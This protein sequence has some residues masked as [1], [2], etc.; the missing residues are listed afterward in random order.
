MN[1]IPLA[2]RNIWE[3][4]ICVRRNDFNAICDVIYILKNQIGFVDG[5]PISDRC[6]GTFSTY[7]LRR[8]QKFSNKIDQLICDV[9]KYPSRCNHCTKDLKGCRCYAVTNF[10]NTFTKMGFPRSGELYFKED[11]S[12]GILTPSAVAN[13][14]K[15][16]PIRDLL[17]KLKTTIGWGICSRQS[18]RFTARFSQFVS[19]CTQRYGSAHKE[20]KNIYAL[21]WTDTC[22]VYIGETTVGYSKRFRKHCNSVISGKEQGNVYDFW[23]KIGLGKVF[24]VPIC[25]V[26][27]AGHTRRARQCIESELIR[28]WGSA[29]NVRSNLSANQYT[30]DGT[31]LVVQKNEKKRPLMKNRGSPKKDFTLKT[32][33]GAPYC[34]FFT[35]DHIKNP[36]EW[37]SVQSH[38]ARMSLKP[39][40]SNDRIMAVKDYY[41][42]QK[43][44]PKFLS[45]I[46]KRAIATLSKFKLTIF[47]KNFVDTIRLHRPLQFMKLSFKSV[48]FRDPVYRAFFEKEVKLFL[49][50]RADITNSKP[51]ILQLNLKPQAPRN[52][53]QYYD[54]S[55]KWCRRMDDSLN[56]KCNEFDPEF[57]IQGHVLT[58]WNAL[59]KKYNLYLPRFWNVKSRLPI[60]WRAEIDS[61]SRQLVTKL[62]VFG[63]RLR[64]SSQSLRERVL[65]VLNC[66]GHTNE[67]DVHMWSKLKE[68]RD[69]LSDYVI[70][71]ID[72]DKGD[73]AIL[74]PAMYKK[75]YVDY[76][77]AS[78]L[79]RTTSSQRSDIL[80]GFFKL[81]TTLVHKPWTGLKKYKTHSWGLLRLLPKR[82]SWNTQPLR[83][84]CMKYRPLV[85]YFSN[86]FAPL[87]SLA[88]RVLN[89][90]LLQLYGDNGHFCLD[91]ATAVRRIRRFRSLHTGGD[92]YIFL[93]NADIDNFYPKAPRDVTIEAVGKLI[94]DFRAKFRRQYITIP[95]KYLNYR[96]Q[97][98]TI[99]SEEYQF[100]TPNKVWG[101]KP[102]ASSH[103]F[104]K[105]HVSVW[106]GSDSVPAID[107][108]LMRIILHDLR[109]SYCLA[110][111]TV[112]YQGCGYPQGSPL[113]TG[114][115]NVFANFCELRHLNAHQLQIRS[116][117]GLLRNRWIDDCVTLVAVKKEDIHR[118]NFEEIFAYFDRKC[119]IYSEDCPLSRVRDFTWEGSTLWQVGNDIW[120]FPANDNYLSLSL[121]STI[122]KLSV[123]SG[124]SSNLRSQ[125]KS[126][127]FGFLIRILDN[128]V[129]PL[130]LVLMQL[131]LTI[132]HFKVLD[133][134]DGIII[135]TISMFELRYPGYINTFQYKY[136]GNLYLLWASIFYL[137]LNLI[138]TNNLLTSSICQLY[139]DN[140][141]FLERRDMF[142]VLLCLSSIRKRL[143]NCL[144]IMFPNPAYS[145]PPPAPKRPP[146]MCQNHLAG[147]C[148]WGPKCFN[149]HIGQETV[150]SQIQAGKIP[151]GYNNQAS[152]TQKGYGS[153]TNYN[154]SQNYAPPQP[155]NVSGPVFSQSAPTSA[156]ERVKAGAQQ[157]PQ[158]PIFNPATDKHLAR[159]SQN[160]QTYALLSVES[161]LVGL[162]ESVTELLSAESTM[163]GSSVTTTQIEQALG[164]FK[165]HLV[166]QG[167][168]PKEDEKQNVDSDF[169][170]SFRLEIDELRRSHNKTT[171]QLRDIKDLLL[172]S[173]SDASENKR[174][175]PC[176]GASKKA[177]S[178]V[179]A[180]PSG[181]NFVEDEDSDEENTDFVMFDL[182]EANRRI[183]ERIDYKRA[184]ISKPTKE[185][186]FEWSLT[187]PVPPAV[188]DFCGP[189][190]FTA[191]LEDCE[192][193]PKWEELVLAL[194]NFENVDKMGNLLM[195]FA[196]VVAAFP[197]NVDLLQAILKTF[198]FKTAIKGKKEMVQTMI[199]ILVILWENL[200]YGKE[201]IW[202][203]KDGHSIPHQDWNDV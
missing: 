3:I 113:G 132:Y 56:C 135:S 38:V 90:M 15:L 80:G 184:N 110:G 138:S 122:S 60:H 155:Y 117:Q 118:Q 71:E 152:N 91:M 83:W 93:H 16:S 65:Q 115:A 37:H 191:P 111:A 189:W 163:C 34:P 101:L 1:F 140:K 66:A 72:K 190:S 4:D 176:P 94:T 24:V 13:R 170:D 97:R 29:L 103:Y 179:K 183:A 158:T 116:V 136:L 40:V 186:R 26:K 23:R 195:I 178:K 187:D 6:I 153:Y 175:R 48:I 75:A 42:Y 145:R 124:V 154:Q 52:L 192:E 47:L 57:R 82:K 120:C 61:I 12:L 167:F 160:P 203:I 105:K 142:D 96:V 147:S 144:T 89:F 180:T 85:P 159:V 123:M 133:Y 129:G 201:N 156:F 137:S 168:A 36:N 98:S 17:Q 2:G 100:R 95:K 9:L 20:S 166:A 174:K 148:K 21:L 202:G 77:S 108:D 177:A 112:L 11:T 197:R 54:N 99:V 182:E 45:R 14:V 172:S 141:G 25:G 119:T 28:L 181:L 127:I 76:I 185:N 109:Y 49:Y 5:D 173:S 107:T 151:Q 126:L 69:D 139:P 114:L 104:W 84:E 150:G 63:N 125:K 171:E 50:E 46:F 102:F 92:S 200:D 58:T 74:C 31:F 169:M 22:Q 130:E 18:T 33:T 67:Q 30:N 44:D 134:T 194:G 27:Y 39:F 121:S 128:T 32:T 59:S 143:A 106:I 81:P 10:A 64:H 79:E 164:G 7:D 41:F 73:L 87:Y 188:R 19:A 78:G 68:I 53:A 86:V 8:I 70:V 88:C 199:C 193:L 62:A 51:I 161:E 162:W 131:W 35:V 157:V 146:T 196:E 43:Q 149:L 198:K 55:R 165:R